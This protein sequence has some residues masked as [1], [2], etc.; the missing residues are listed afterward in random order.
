MANIVTINVA[1]E[2]SRFP[3]G[4]FLEDG[5]FSG[6]RFRDE[7][8]VPALETNSHVQVELDGTLGY[9]SSFLEEAFGGLVREAGFKPEEVLQNLILETSNETLRFTIHS[10][11]QQAKPNRM[12]HH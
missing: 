9:G 11:I 5:E 8:L 12:A 10:Y 2:F 7:F 4:R 3:G 6:Q 1:K